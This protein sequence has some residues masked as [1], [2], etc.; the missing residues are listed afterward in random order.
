MISLPEHAFDQLEQFILSNREEGSGTQPLELMSLSAKPGV[1][2]VIT[3]KNYVGVIT[4]RDGTE[5]EILPKLTIEGD[6]SDQA[7]RKVFLTML[8]T[9]QE[10]PFKTFRT[11]HLNTSRMRLLDLFVRMFLDE[12]H[13][14]IQRGLKSDYTARQDNEPCV[15]GKIVFSEHIRK[16]LLHRERIFVEYDVFSVDC[17]E[18]RLVKSTAVYLQ[19]HATDLQNRKDLRIVLSVM[20]QVPVSKHVEQDFLRCGQSR[21]MADYRRLLELCRVFLQGK[22]FTAFS[23]GEAALALLFPMERVFESYVAAVLRRHLDSRQYRVHVQAKG[24]YLFELPR[25]QFALRP[26]LVIEDLNSGERTILDTKWKL[27]SPQWHNYGI[28]QADMYQ[29][30]AYQKEYAAKQ[31]VLLYPDCEAMAGQKSPLCYSSPS[32]SLVIVQTLRLDSPIAMAEAVKELLDVA[33]QPSK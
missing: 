20:D 13:R 32:G 28:S 19:R 2:K 24:K 7:V 9:V 21:S 11:A 14:L 6:D 31:V 4:T 10:A 18:N 1:G 3:A 12:A 30:Y 8:R 29:M 25:K 33:S 23:G 22:S 15:R 27:L 26:D 17:P 16:N 5:I